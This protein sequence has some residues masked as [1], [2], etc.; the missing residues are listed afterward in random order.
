MIVRQTQVGEDER[1][2]LIIE[3]G[4][5]LALPVEVLEAREERDVVL[6][7]VPQRPIPPRMFATDRFATIRDSAS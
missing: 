7:E 5:G 3:S 4:T 2:Q 1:P 6:R